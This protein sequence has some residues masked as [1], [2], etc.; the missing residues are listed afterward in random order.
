MIAH[1]LRGEP[2]RELAGV[3]LDQETDHA[4]VRAQGCPVDAQRG[5]FLALLVDEGQ[6]KAFGDG[7]VHL[8]GGQGE[9]APDGAPDLDI[10]LGAVE[11]GFV[12]HFHIRY[13]AVVHRPAHHLFGLEPQLAVIDVLLT[14]T[15]R[16]V[17]REAHDVL[18]D[19]EDLEVFLVD[20]DHV[21][22]FLL[23]VFFRAVDVGIVH[24][25]R[26][27]AHQPEQLAAFLV[28]VAGAVLAQADR[29]VAVAAQSGCQ[30]SCGGRGSSSA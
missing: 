15:F 30:R 13:T 9:L 7:K 12:G 23:E 8:V 22:E 1:L 14:Q 19:A 21:H 4:L 18:V 25:H 2:H 27:H 29:Q 11:G 3:M 6:V 10:D 26:A 5:L 24:L 20:V 16:V 17:Q 28:A